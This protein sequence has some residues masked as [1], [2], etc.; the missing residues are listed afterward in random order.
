MGLGLIGCK[1]GMTRIFTDE[2]VAVPVTVLDMSTNRIA[3]IKSTKPDG[4]TAIQM[5]YGIRK[6]NRL[7]R[8]CA[9]HFA[10]AGIE[11]AR[12][13]HEFLVPSEM[14]ADA[15]LGDV[16]NV[17]LF[18]AHQWVDAT[19]I[20]K[21]KGFSGVIKRHHFSS[22]RASHGNSVSHRSP[23]SIGQN[24]DPGRVFPGKRMAGQLGNVQRTVQR[25]KIVKID[26]ERQLLF[27]KGSVPGS[28]GS[29]VIICPSVKEAK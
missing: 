16:M 1:V 18:K 4:Y 20:S 12:V 10:K 13:L 14:L 27:L 21:G 6:V 28:T 26:Q 17:D 23:G 8:S 7:T 25:L 2:G 3:Q 22:N 15:K 5:A 29:Q 11:A 19:G 9:G 24:Q